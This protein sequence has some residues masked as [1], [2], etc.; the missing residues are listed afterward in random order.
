MRR[1]NNCAFFITALCL[2]VAAYPTAAAAQ[3]AAIHD[4]R[5]DNAVNPRGVKTP[6]PQLSWTW[7][8][9]RTPRA[10]QVLVA[11]SEEKLKADEG[12]LWDSGRVLSDKKTVQYQGRPLT[13]LQHCFWKVR[14]WNDYDTAGGYTEPANW[15]MGLLFFDSPESK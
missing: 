4:L 2:V 6:R 7:A 10:F 3:G 5:C 9:A 15:Q 8:Q 12:D 14:V 1:R 11:S 13:S